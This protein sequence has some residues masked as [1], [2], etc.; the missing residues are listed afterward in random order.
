MYKLTSQS[1]LENYLNLNN[2]IYIIAIQ[3]IHSNACDLNGLIFVTTNGKS[4]DS[5]KGVLTDYNTTTC[6]QQA[7]LYLRLNTSDG[8]YFSQRGILKTPATCIMFKIYEV[9]FNKIT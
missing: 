1:H 7:R 2:Y 5:M 9:T 3:R 8:K 6:K 4:S